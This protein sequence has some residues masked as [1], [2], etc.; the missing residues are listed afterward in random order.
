MADP[1]TTRRPRGRSADAA[2]RRKAERRA[3]L[4]VNPDSSLAAD[5]AELLQARRHPP[6][7]VA[8]GAERRRSGAAGIVWLDRPAPIRDGG[9]AC[10]VG[11][12][13]GTTLPAWLAEQL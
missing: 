8:P 1:T 7:A 6:P 3:R 11:Y 13:D 12:A 9:R 2:T 5:R 10:V 4:G